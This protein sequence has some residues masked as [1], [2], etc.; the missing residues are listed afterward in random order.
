MNARHA[1]WLSTAKSD[2]EFAEVGLA[3]KFPVQTCFLSQQAVEKALKGVLVFLKRPYPKTHSLLEL[4]RL[5]PELDL[6]PHRLNL[7]ILDGYYAPLRYPD[8]LPKGGPLDTVGA[9]EA[10]EAVALARIVYNLASAL[11][12]QP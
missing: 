3:K 4:S 7:T 8:A 9:K 6:K 12:S 10:K 5:V 11:T 2:L 1:D